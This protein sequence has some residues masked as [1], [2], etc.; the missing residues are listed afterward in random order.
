MNDSELDRALALQERADALASEGDAAGAEAALRESIALFEAMDG[1]ESPDVANLLRLLGGAMIAQGRYQEAADCAARAI[2]IMDKVL[3]LMEGPEGP[4]I[5]VEALAVEGTALREAGLY[6]KAEPVLRRAIAVC[7]SELPFE[8]AML[9]NALNN[10]GMLC[11]YNGN[12]EEGAQAYERAMGLAIEEAGEMSSMVAVLNHNIGGLE[13]SRG[14][15]AAAEG[16]ARRAWE[17]RRELLK[18]DVHLDVHADACAYGGVLDGLGRHAESKAIYEKAL[19][20][21]EEHYGPVHFEVA[22]TLNNL[23]SAESGLG[24]TGAA[25]RHGQRALDIKRQLL[26]EDHPEWALTANN[27]AMLLFE[28]GKRDEAVSL[29]QRAAHTVQQR[30][31]EGHPIRLRIEENLASLL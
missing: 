23:A 11:K 2:A 4:Q 15:Y 3:P 6:P 26:G 20:A 25:I 19:I 31:D 21:Y 9:A 12:F 1:P 29:L 5:L 13:H 30:L 18:D 28:V 7:E 14:N 17:I 8:K 16:P 22:A 10:F 24:D 27:L